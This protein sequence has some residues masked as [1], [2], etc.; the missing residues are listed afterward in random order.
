MSTIIARL[1]ND[2]WVATEAKVESLA[3]ER[4]NN[5]AS[6]LRIDGTY[7]RVLVVATQAKIGRNKRGRPNAEAQT[8]VLNEVHERFYAAVLRGVTTHDIE[9]DDDQTPTERTRRSLERNRRSAFARSAKSTLALYVEGGGDLRGLD[10]STVTKTSLRAAIA[11]PEPTNKVE[12]QIKRA[13]ES[14]FRAYKRRAKSDPD[15]T[16]ESIESTIASLREILESLDGDSDH[17][18]TTVPSRPRPA[19]RN[20]HQRTRVGTP[21]LN[22]SA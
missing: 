9:I 6:V 10:A 7:L 5:A 8:A 4:Y 21:M 1:E 18:T 22:R 12:R 11:P 2:H 14:L 15:G 13:S 20:N 3:L 19:E 16:A 17:G